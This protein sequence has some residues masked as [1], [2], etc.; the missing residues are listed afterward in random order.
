MPQPPAGRLRP[1][2]PPTASLEHDRPALRPTDS[3][4][5]LQSLA[6]PITVLL[7]LYVVVQVVHLAHLGAAIQAM[8]SVLDG[9]AS[10]DVTGSAIDRRAAIIKNLPA[11]V[12][13]PLA[14]L[15][16]LFVARANRNVR[17]L[18]VLE[19]R[20]TP[21][22]AVGVFFIPVWNF[23]KP[24]QVMRE[25]WQGSNPDSDPVVIAS[26]LRGTPLLMWWWAL[27]VASFV[28]VQGFYQGPGPAAFIGRAEMAMVGH[29]VDLAAA[30][31]AIAVVRGLAARQD[32]CQRVAAAR[33]T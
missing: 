25:L 9:G 4:R 11:L 15:F 5:S 3:I 26:S 28:Q 6:L 12:H 27:Y 29:L 16:C 1:N 21:A 33:L 7:D 23:Y 10:L 31:L 30:L 13:L 14:V 8:Q 24:Y 32:A 17:A 18:H 19:P 2:A 22:W 20:F